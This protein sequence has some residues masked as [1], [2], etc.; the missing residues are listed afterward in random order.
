V[1][2][3]SWNAAIER[4]AFFTGF[5]GKT[6]LIGDISK[7]G[8]ELGQ[9][10]IEEVDNEGR[11]IAITAPTGALAID[12]V[13][14]SLKLQLNDGVRVQSSADGLDVQ[15]LEFATLDLPLEVT[16][17]EPFRNRGDKES[18]LT[19]KEL[20]NARIDRSSGLSTFDVSAELNYRA[21]RVLS[22][23]F[24]PFL[25]IPFGLSSRRSP[26]NIRLLIGIVLLVGY[27]EIVQ[28]GQS[29]VEER[30]ARRCSPC[31]CRL[32]RSH[33]PACGCS[34]RPTGASVRTRWGRFSIASTMRPV[35]YRGHFWRSF[36]DEG[37]HE[38][39]SALCPQALSLELRH[40]VAGALRPASDF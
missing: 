28:L 3:T 5:G 11:N 10:F 8:R 17:P 18:E 13:D 35:G 30:F 9:I 29:L 25:A 19:L 15:A 23:M 39:L 31:G 6:M 1:G 2:E 36:V 27:F 24:L 14:Y 12:P 22:V 34:T 38:D 40:R 26:R 37:R 32:P 16:A 21:V 33:C 20:L 7:G 4:G